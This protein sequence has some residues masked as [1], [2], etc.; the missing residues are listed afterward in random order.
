MIRI[1]IS[2]K[3]KMKKSFADKLIIMICILIV[4]VLFVSFIYPAVYVLISSVSTTAMRGVGSLV[5]NKISFE[6]Y[7]AVFE[8]ETIWNGLKNSVLYT[9]VGTLVSLS[10][11]IL[12]AYPM[13]RPNFHMEKYIQVIFIFTMYFSGGML[14][15][16]LLVKKLGMINS[17]WSLILP[18]CISVYNIFLLRSHFKS[19]IPQELFDAARIDGC[20]HWRF[21]IK[22]AIPM[23][24]SFLMVIAFFYMISYWNS[25]F[26]AMI[27]ITDADKLPLANILNNILIKNQ[28]GSFGTGASG[29]TSVISS[30]ERLQLLEYAL[31]VVSSLPIIAIVVLFKKLPF[32]HNSFDIYKF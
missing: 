18:S 9:T 4:L 27:Y 11:T 25:Y 22:V 1:K 16:Y 15:T 19:K 8:S 21:L 13:S 28:S 17:M 32:K 2:K 31:I 23:S 24:V 3:R 7:K 5:P 12:T 10:I 6:G 26:N 20:G 14:P 30:A 29:S